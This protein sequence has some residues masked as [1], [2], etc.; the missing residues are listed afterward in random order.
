MKICRIVFLTIALIVMFSPEGFCF[1]RHHPIV[2]IPF[3]FIPPPVI[4][5]EI[6]EPS[7]TVIE[8][9]QRREMIRAV[10]QLA[11]PNHGV[12]RRYHGGSIALPDGYA[13][14][15]RDRKIADGKWIVQYHFVP[16]EEQDWRTYPRREPPDPPAG[17]VNKKRLLQLENGQ[18]VKQFITITVDEDEEA[19]E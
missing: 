12:W 7:P 18:N 11:D 17:F 5:V 19:D 8:V 2:P 13:L 10:P 3:P 9:P 16:E 6:P 15:M 4:S 14:E 1:H